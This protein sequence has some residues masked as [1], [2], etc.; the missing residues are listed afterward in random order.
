MEYRNKFAPVHICSNWQ[1]VCMLEGVCGDS[2]SQ[3]IPVLIPSW[4]CIVPEHGETSQGS[5]L[6]N[7]HEKPQLAEFWML[8]APFC[9]YAKLHHPRRKSLEFWLVCGTQN[10]FLFLRVGESFVSNWPHNGPETIWFFLLT[11]EY[12]WS[13][14]LQGK[15]VVCWGPKE[16]VNRSWVSNALAEDCNPV[17]FRF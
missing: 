8:F 5:L 2:P 14:E 16:Q 11:S 9:S 13:L 10:S 17:Q 7:S 12:P 4:L 3:S 1:K 6:S 15:Q